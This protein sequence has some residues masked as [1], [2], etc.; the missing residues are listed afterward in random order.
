MASQ[1]RIPQPALSVV[2]AVLTALGPYSQAQ[3]PAAAA[4]A[5]DLQEVVVTGSRILTTR[6]AEA[7]PLRVLS[8]E[9]IEKQGSPSLLE[10]I[11]ALPEAAG[12]LGN[13]N[14]SQPGKGQGFEASE[15]VNLRGLGPDR[16]L[17]LLNGRRLPL[18]SG[19]HVNTR[20]I[21]IS[22]IERIEVLKDA[23]ATTYGSDAVSGVVNF[24]TKRNFEGLEVG[25]DFTSIEDTDGDYKLDA[26][27]GRVGDGWN[28]MLSGGYQDRSRLWQRDRDWAIPPYTLNPDAGWNFSA[29]PAQFV[30]VGP[31]GPGGTLAAV[32]PRAVDVGCRALG[33]L[34]VTFA[35]NDFCIN[36]VTRWQSLVAPATTWQTYGEFNKDFGESTRLHV[37]GYYSQSEALMD[38]PPSFNQPKPVTETVLPSNINPAGFTPGTSPRLFGNW[39][40]PLTNPG[41]A[42]Y[43]AANPTQFPA[44]ATGIFI[45]IGQ[46]RPWLVG[47]N[48][49]FGSDLDGSAY[50]TR[51]QKEWRVSAGLEGKFGENIGWKADFTRGQNKHTLLGW[52]STGVQIQLA[53]RG[54]GGPNCPWQTAAPGSPGCLWLNP[55]S[56][57][58]PGAP[59]NGVPVNPTFNPAV[60]N[61]I[62]LANW[63]MIPQQRELTSDTTEVNA[64]LDGDFGWTL[65]GGAVKWAAGLQYR[66]IA[67]NETDSEFADRTQ[68]PC[69]N[70]PL[71]IP[72][73]DLC[74]PTPNSP[75]GLAAAFAPTDISTDIYAGFAEVVLPFT[76]RSNLTLGARY[77]DAGA[78]GG[79]TF[80]PQVRGKVQVTDWL[81]IRASGSTAFRAPPQTSLAPN[82][83]AQIPT[84]LGQPRA[85][86]VIGNPDLEPEEATVFSVGLIVQAGNFDA[87][88][89]YYSY[90]LENIL[91]TEPQNAI[92]NA[93]FPNGAAGANNCATLDAKFISD[94]FVFT[95]PCSAANLQKVQLLRING[96]EAKFDGLD[97]RASY[98][99][100]GVFGGG[101]TLGVVANQTLNYEY[102]PFSVAG[103]A[104][105]G[106]E[107]VGRLNVG[108]LANT[109]PEYK[110][111]AWVNYDRGPVNLRW[112]S[113][114]S[115]SYID[116]RQAVTAVGYSIASTTLHDF[117]AVIGLPRNLSLTLAVSNIFD[118]EPP[119]VR[120]AEAYDPMTSDALGRNYRVGLRMQF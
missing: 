28:V 103:L 8:R 54:L 67:F 109:L 97:L 9:D 90:R 52:D 17:V 82:P 93:L 75:L 117:A 85:L 45:P 44:N 112:S 60:A 51:D 77:E 3:N 22:A 96:P 46:W 24:I 108:T 84:I 71:N 30:P 19:Y 35:P 1:P 66:N 47:G 69:L 31:T 105:A 74:T 79:S 49:F 89:D 87:A 113:R 95:G 98:R 65:G 58:V 56:T 115:S 70:S 57:A 63:L 39:F 80:N 32:G 27:W 100:D 107:A 48:P 16:N 73:A 78:D 106:F 43:R 62:E 83:S 72:N 10:T 15:S 55:T 119:L 92:V 91:T 76:E 13:T 6:Q 61:S 2:A 81:A 26:T 53:L 18:V 102:D 14:A 120:V 38:Y 34:V 59:I 4:T 12:S 88:L 116:Q 40:V 101:L 42:A 86:D 29:N 25:G 68:V 50:Q 41:L 99:F 7:L 5:T 20:N 33:S 111:Q 36:Q 11:R 104:I 37:E 21:P 94:H 118:E 110:G 23:A 64:E 114:Y